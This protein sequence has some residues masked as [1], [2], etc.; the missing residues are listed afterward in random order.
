MT[1]ITRR[2]KTLTVTPAPPGLYEH[3]GYHHT[4]FN[5]ERGGLSSQREWKNL[6]KSGTNGFVTLPGYYSDVVD[7]LG[8][9]KIEFTVNNK[10]KIIPWRPDWVDMSDQTEIGKRFLNA[11]QEGVNGLLIGPCG[12]GKTHIIKGLIEGLQA[13]K[14]LITADD[15]GGAKQLRDSLRTLL[16]DEQ[17]GIWCSEVKDVPKKITITTNSSIKAIAMNPAFAKAGLSLADFEV[18]IADEVHTLPT[19]AVLPYIAQIKAPCRIGL[20]ATLK[21]KDGA[22]YLLRGYFGEVIEEVSYNEAVEGKRVVPVKVFIFPVPYIQE[23]CPKLSAKDEDWRVISMGLVHYKPLHAIIKGIQERLPKDSQHIIFAQWYKYCEILKKRLKPANALVLHAKQPISQIEGIKRRLKEG[24]PGIVI[25]TS[26]IEK[27]FNAPT[28]Q[29]VT[30]AALGSRSDK[31]QRAGRA[32][33]IFEGKT[34]AQVHDFLYLHHPTLLKASIGSIKA[35]KELGW[36]VKLMI[37]KADFKL[38]VEKH[39]PRLGSYSELLETLLPLAC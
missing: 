1:I 38:M 19:P 17:I 26:L 31:I 12:V 29:Y 9:K 36:D 13:E 33:R 6:G 15:I 7:F 3:L 24:E 37:T 4:S 27:A 22:D 11:I 14:I 21:R 8:A 2:D 35:Y 23:A 25:T 28:V 16:P 39:S 32:S 30:M 18:W 10:R 20:T 34:H 5:N